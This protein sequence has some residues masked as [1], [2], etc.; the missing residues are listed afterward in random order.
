MCYSD[1]AFALIYV[2]LC[3][4]VSS[5]LII[6]EACNFQIHISS[7]KVQVSFGDKKKL[8]ESPIAIGLAEVNSSRIALSFMKLSLL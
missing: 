4:S 5:N 2:R 1:I 3:V 6:S 8:L 7:E